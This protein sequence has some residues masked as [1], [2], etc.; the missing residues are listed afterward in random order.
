MK[1][2]HSWKKYSSHILVHYR[3]WYYSMETPWLSHSSPI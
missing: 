2:C 3:T 1:R